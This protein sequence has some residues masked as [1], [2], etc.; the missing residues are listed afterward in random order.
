MLW[1]EW[2][3]G[4][5]PLL[6]ATAAPARVVRHRGEMWVSPVHC[7]LTRTD[8]NGPREGHCCPK[9]ACA[10]WQ[11]AAPLF[12]W[13]CQL[14][15][16]YYQGLQSGCYPFALT[17]LSWGR[18]CLRAFLS[19]F[20]SLAILPIPDIKLRFI[21]GLNASGEG[22]SK[23]KF[24]VHKVPR[25]QIAALLVSSLAQDHSILE[26]YSGGTLCCWTVIPWWVELWTYSHNISGR[27]PSRRIPENLA[28][29]VLPVTAVRSPE[30]FESDTWDRYLSHIAHGPT[31]WLTLSSFIFFLCLVPL[32]Y[33]CLSSSW[34]VSPV[35]ASPFLKNCLWTLFCCKPVAVIVT[36]TI[37]SLCV[38][39][40]SSLWTL[41]LAINQS[42]KHL[43]LFIYPRHSL[44]QALDKYFYYLTLSWQWFVPASTQ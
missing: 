30:A 33:D 38:A 35:L 41:S 42:Q 8:Q 5:E 44:G 7:V 28:L 10:H 40:Y 31:F 26:S 34:C 29:C 14:L 39:L 1:P 6:P 11:K 25:L 43:Q 24:R 23:R 21:I 9:L 37:F 13:L 20:S 12:S 36:W 27:P 17:L 19:R 3:F 32:I 4:E 2:H 18:D 22:I 16:S 15:S